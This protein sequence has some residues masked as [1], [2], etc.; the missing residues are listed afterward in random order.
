MLALSS[1]G[2]ECEYNTG[3]VETRLA[4]LHRKNRALETERDEARDRTSTGPGVVARVP[5]ATSPRR[6]AKC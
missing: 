1:V 6:D 2:E 3:E 5:Q 4:A